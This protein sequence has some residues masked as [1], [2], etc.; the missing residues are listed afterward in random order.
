[1]KDGAA[2]ADLDGA[3]VEP[4]GDF[5]QVTV[6]AGCCNT[7]ANAHVGVGVWCG[8][9]RDVGKYRRRGATLWLYFLLEWRL[10]YPGL[11]SEITTTPASRGPGVEAVHGLPVWLEVL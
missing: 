4:D 10:G 7:R 5:A 11:D 8:R 3:E 6:G 1:M 2:F 9:G